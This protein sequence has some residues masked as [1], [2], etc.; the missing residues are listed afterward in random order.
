MLLCMV[1]G[2]VGAS[3]PARGL[4]AGAILGRCG[5]SWAAKRSGACFVEKQNMGGT[6]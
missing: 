3:F 6:P 4:S 2:A 5:Y 1:R